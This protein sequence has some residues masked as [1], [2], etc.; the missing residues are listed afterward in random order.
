MLDFLKITPRSVKRGVTEIA[1]TFKIGKSDDLMI[2]G[3]DFYAIWN[4]EKWSTDENDVIDLIDNELRRVSEEY[5]K[6]TTDN[7]DVKY[8]WNASSGSIDAW[9]KYCQ[10]QCRDSFHNLDEKLVF[11]NTDIQ[12]EDY[13]SKQLNYPLAPGNID[14]YT[15]LMTTLYSEEEL[16]KIEWSIGSIVSGDSRRIQKFIVLYGSA[17]TGKSTVLNIIQK[18]FDGYYAVFD[19]KAL[20]SSSNAFALESFK[21]NPLVAIQHDGDLSRI[22]DNTRLNSLV[23]HET[24]TVNTKFRP[25][26]STAFNAFL[27]MGTNKPVKI[28]DAKSGLL[29]RLIDVTPTGNKVDLATYRK[30]VKKIDY[31]LGGIAYHCLE[32]YNEDPSYYDSYIPVNMMGA[33]NDFYNFI[34]D[35]LL[36]FQRDDAT[37][38]KSAWEM[39]KMYCADANIAYPFSQRV[40]KEE[41]KNYFRDYYDRYTA[42]DGTRY[43]SYFCGFLSEKFQPAA[44][45]KG[46][47][48]KQAESWLDLKEQPSKLD[49]ICADCFA[50]NAITTPQGSEI[51]G[52]AWSKVTTTLKELDT[53]VT[54]YLKPQANHIVLDFDKKTPDG[55]KSLELNIEAASKYPATYAEVSK[56]GHGLHLHYFYEGDVNELANM[57]EPDIE[58]KLPKGNSAIRRRLSLCNALTMA[59]IGSGLPLKKKKGGSKMLETSHIQSEIALRKLIEKSLKRELPNVGPHTAPNVDFIK[60][61]LDDAYNSGL[62]YNVFDLKQA[63]VVFGMGS[64][65]QAA[66]CMRAITKMHFYSDDQKEEVLGKPEETGDQNG[67]DDDSDLWFFDVEVYPN[68]FLLCYK[69]KGEGN[70]VHRLY[71]PTPGQLEEVLKK[72]LVGFNCR[73]YDNHICYGSY[74]GKTNDELFQISQKI[75]NSKKGDKNPAFFPKAYNL[76][77][78]DVYDFASASHKQSLK[79][80]EIQ[81]KIRHK[82]MEIPWDRPVPESMWGLVGDYC[83]NDVLATEAVFDYLLSDWVSHKILAKLAGLSYNDTTNACTTKIIFGNDK[84]PQSQFNY[85]DLS[86]P[87]KT[88]PDDVLK[89]LTE[90]FP[91]MMRESFKP[92]WCD[93]EPSLLPYFPGYSFERGISTYRG[94]E[95]GEGGNVFAVPGMYT[96]VALLD[97]ASMHPHSGLAECLF[98][99]KYSTAYYQI[100]DGRVSIKHEAW[101][102]MDQV[103]GGRLKPFIQWVKDGIITSKDLAT[104]LKTAINSVYGLTAAGFSNPFRDP[105]NVDNIVAKRGALF[106]EDLKHAVLDQGYEVAHIKTDSIKI[107]NATPEII[108]FVMDF[109]KRYGYTFEHEAT[110]ERTCLVNDAVYI[111]KYETAENCEKMYGYVPDDNAKYSGEWT[112]T[113]TQFA[114]PYV[115]KS[116]FSGEELVFD[117]YCVT[118]AVKSALY[119]DKNESLPD[120]LEDE[121]K[122]EKLQ[123]KY[124]KAAN[125]EEADS[126]SQELTALTERIKNGHNYV[127]VGRVGQFTPV[128]SGANGGLLVR[129][130]NGKMYAAAGTTGY[131]WMESVDVES[132]NKESLI[133][134]SYF[135]NLASDALEAISKY[136]DAE[137]FRSGEPCVIYTRKQPGETS[138]RTDIYGNPIG[139]ID[140]PF[141]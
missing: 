122:Y 41:L 85:R 117:D 44:P 135:Q 62:S 13:A 92:S 69:K 80:Y 19:A 115:F 3:G 24:M 42:D 106:M 12:K 16:H 128:V 52:R 37:T 126:I 15:E 9:H 23:S 20:G 68:L 61:I 120:V 36:V 34:E 43:R 32:V 130:Q 48:K 101:D 25:E 127:F 78:A 98:G 57:I 10:K 59:V 35:S 40:F 58:I 89:F 53:H 50:Q 54:H 131:R 129:E 6:K 2:R 38:L 17:G 73:R 27:Y 8:M 4:G 99:V 29:R 102:K 56:G 11:S 60:M 28:T 105:R 111:A 1:P 125:Q 14:A 121:A 84:T 107:P 137:A 5:A 95:I 76:S 116:L 7:L 71:N 113:G 134:Y 83:D 66:N 97:V 70:P 31:E 79:K 45:V 96:N 93:G 110:Y 55:Q 133:D 87:V 26:Y 74:I 90:L 51:P 49:E 108:K 67:M 63:I 136:G 123:K 94:R 141:C 119:L 77:Y 114:V 75:I 118:F 65:N 30:L 22:E 132:L 140:L 33:S 39:Y 47:P 18:L 104:A 21:T 100:V 139:D 64:S 46:K 103:L 112:A 82:E 124:F 81:L 86:K 138:G 72:K 109:G 88:L 91:D